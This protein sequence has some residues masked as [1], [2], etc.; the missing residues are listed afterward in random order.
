MFF[1]QENFM[2]GI[3]IL[4]DKYNTKISLFEILKN[5]LSI[6]V[7]DKRQVSPKKGLLSKFLFSL[8]NI[9]Y[10]K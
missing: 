1:Y 4:L 10:R 8:H 7:K 2:T 5:T 6:Y 3:V 9:N